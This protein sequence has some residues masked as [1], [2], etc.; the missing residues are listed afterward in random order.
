MGFLLVFDATVEVRG[1]RPKKPWRG[2][3]AIRDGLGSCAFCCSAGIVEDSNGD[4]QQY[5]FAISVWIL[6]VGWAPSPK[7]STSAVQGT[8]LNYDGKPNRNLYYLQYIYIYTV[9]IPD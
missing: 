1:K 2:S 9:M 5:L 7:S 3:T 4:V 6:S 8:H